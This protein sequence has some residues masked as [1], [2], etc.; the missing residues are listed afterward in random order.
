MKV[1]Y[2]GVSTLEQNP[3]LQHHALKQAGCE[4]IFTDH[5][6]GAKVDR[7][8]LTEALGYACSGDC[9]VVLRLDRLGHLIEVVEDLK[10]RKVEFSSVQE[11][12]D[13][14]T[15]GGRLVPHLF[16]ALAEFE[17]NLIRERTKVGPSAVRAWADESPS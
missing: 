10:S 1:G 3:D 11:G 6:S 9:L 8:A 17:R 7:P 13:T 2:A 4:K 16:G 14:T 12:I 15:S 5:A